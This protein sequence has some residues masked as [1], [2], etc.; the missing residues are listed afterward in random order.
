[1]NENQV[2]QSQVHVTAKWYLICKPGKRGLNS[3]LRPVLRVGGTGSDTLPYH[4][5][6]N[7][8]STTLVKGHNQRYIIIFDWERR[9]SQIRF[10]AIQYFMQ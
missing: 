2:C 8:R 4:V 9:Y 6:G 5:T 1:M 3:Q 7:G 10:P